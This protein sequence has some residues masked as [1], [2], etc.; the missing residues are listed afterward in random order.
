MKLIL[1]ALALLTTSVTAKEYGNI[2]VD[3]VISVY[4]GDTFRVT[5]AGYPAL[6]GENIPIRV[7][8]IDTPEIRGKCD[9]ERQLAI[10]AREF[11]KSFLTGG[12]IELRSIRRGKYFRIAADVY[13]K[14]LGDSLIKANL[15]YKYN[16]KSKRNWCK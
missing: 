11:T 16:K 1:L 8:R 13:G 15:A 5:I 3:K 9:Y 10:E 12:V 2:T 7:N 4:D 14:G 6:I